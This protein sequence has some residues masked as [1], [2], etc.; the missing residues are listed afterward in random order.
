[1]T[2]EVLE[3]LMSPD[4]PFFRLST[5]GHAGSA[6]VSGRNFEILLALFYMAT[7]LEMALWWKVT[8][9][10]DTFL[11]APLKHFYN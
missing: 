5:F 7:W 9:L 8:F 4:S 1:M 10:K 6:H 11:V 3:I 2:S